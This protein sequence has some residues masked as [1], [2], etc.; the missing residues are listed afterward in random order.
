MYVTGVSIQCS[1]ALMYALGL[2]IQRASFVVEQGKER[3]PVGCRGALCKA[4]T[5]LT[6]LAGL[7]IYGIGGIF[8]STM[9]LRYIPLSLSSAIFTLVMVFNAIVA[10]LWLKEV[11]WPSVRVSPSAVLP[12]FATHHM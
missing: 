1:A 3:P 9:S 12:S 8:L 5:T 6:W 11:P 4:H 10:R 7:V 2:C